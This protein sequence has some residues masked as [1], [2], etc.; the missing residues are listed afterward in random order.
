M[1]ARKTMKTFFA[2]MNEQVGMGGYGPKIKSTPMGPFRWNDLTQLW[3]NVNNGMVMNNVSF[4]DMFMMGYDV[5]SGD[6]GTTVSVD[7]TPTLTPAD[8]GNLDTMDTASTDYWASS[9][10]AQLLVASAANVAFSGLGASISVTITTS[11]GTGSAHPS[12]IKYSLNG[13]A[14]QT[15][16]TALTISNTDTL[17]IGVSTPGGIGVGTGN[18]VVTNATTSTVLDQ[19]PYTINIE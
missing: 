5:D 14:A 13:A 19:I 16:S 18:I 4:Q 12:A 2:A 8:W 6:N 11:T 1:S 3:E 9:T 7:Y 17:K 15:Y 10:G